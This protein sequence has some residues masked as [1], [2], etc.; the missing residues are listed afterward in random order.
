MRLRP[1]STRTALRAQ[2]LQGRRFLALSKA[3]Q[4]WM[5]PAWGSSAAEVPIETQ[6]L[7]LEAAGELAE[8]GQGAGEAVYALLLPLIDGNRFR[9]SLR[10]ARC[11]GW[12]GVDGVECACTMIWPAVDPPC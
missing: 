10:P 4:Y 9:G 7:L 3:K 2:L 6:L 5:V 11:A 12:M 1:P 8:E